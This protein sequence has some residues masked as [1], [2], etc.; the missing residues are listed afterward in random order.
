[1]CIIFAYIEDGKMKR[2]KQETRKERRE[3]RRKE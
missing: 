3:E 2:R 1:V